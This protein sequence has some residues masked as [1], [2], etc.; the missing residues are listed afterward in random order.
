MTILLFFT[1]T[2]VLCA[3]SSERLKADDANTIAIYKIREKAKA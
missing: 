1:W 3:T 2:V